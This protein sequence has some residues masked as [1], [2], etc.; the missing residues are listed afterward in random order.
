MLQH[1]YVTNIIVITISQ[2]ID[3]TALATP[4][5]NTTSTNAQRK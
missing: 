4:I 1:Y 2:Y 3:V 5:Q